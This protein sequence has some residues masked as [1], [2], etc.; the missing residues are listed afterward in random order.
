MSSPTATPAATPIANAGE[1]R[2]PLA[3]PVPTEDGLLPAAAAT[4][5]AANDNDLTTLSTQVYLERTVLG[6]LA[7]ALEDV[8]RVRPPNPV[9]YLGS[10]LLRRSTANNT[11]EVSYEDTVPKAVP[12]TDE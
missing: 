5:A 2:P 10:Y 11:V 12:T 4:N 1:E 8:C 7:L 6:V 9:D 3:A